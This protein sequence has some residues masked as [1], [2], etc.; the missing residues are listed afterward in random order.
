[1]HLRR[2][3]VVLFSCLLAV[4]SPDPVAQDPM[5]PPSA[6]QR[7]AELARPAEPH[8]RLQRLLGSWQVTSTTTT[9]AG[10]EARVERGTIEGTSLLGGRYVMLHYRLQVEGGGLEAVQL[11]GFHTLHQLYTS[12]WRDDHSTWAIECNGPPD[13]AAPDRLVLHGTL[14]DVQDAEGHPFR[15]ELD[16]GD[17][18]VEV[19]LFETVGGAPVLRQTQQWTRA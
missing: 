4:S 5:P 18:R 8:Q 1:M 13:A 14:V 17:E 11:L 2:S 10:A 6:L 3:G 9:A 19:R 15:L 16:L 7:A 12:S